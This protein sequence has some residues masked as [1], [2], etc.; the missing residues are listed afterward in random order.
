[1]NIFAHISTGYFS[2]SV[3]PDQDKTYDKLITREGTSSAYI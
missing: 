2:L 3:W 1:M